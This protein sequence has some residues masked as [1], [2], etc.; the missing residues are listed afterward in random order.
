MPTVLVV[1][2]SMTGNT[3]AAAK[4][5]AKGAEEAGAKV[6]VKTARETSSQDLIAC[7]GVAFGSYDAFSYMGGDLKDLFDRTLYPTQ[8]KTDGKPFVAFITHGG[9]GG[10]IKSI[11]SVAGSLKLRRAATSVS[12]KGRPN[13]E[14]S[15]Q[16]AA[17]GA[18]LVEALKS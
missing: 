6:T 7:D 12:V 4:A 11:E 3:E 17:L 9:G 13:E 16:L 15:A 18:K 5:V 1:Y 2:N 14:S 8:G 10:A